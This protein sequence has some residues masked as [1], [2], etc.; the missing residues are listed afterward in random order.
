MWISKVKKNVY[1]PNYSYNIIIINKKFLKTWT[2]HLK[3]HK[4]KG[5]CGG[6]FEMGCTVCVFYNRVLAPSCGV[7]VYLL[8]FNNFQSKQMWNYY[9]VP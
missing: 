6:V 2:L 4:N 8:K 9:K 3:K 5:F 7:K 1:Y